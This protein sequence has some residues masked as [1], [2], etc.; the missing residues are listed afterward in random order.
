MAQ[1]QKL[2]FGDDITALIR[3]AKRDKFAKEEDQRIV[4]VVEI[5]LQLT[6]QTLFQDIA[7]QKHLNELLD[8]DLEQRISLL[9]AATTSDSNEDK[10]E[11]NKEAEKNEEKKDEKEEVH[12]QKTN[13]QNVNEKV[14]NK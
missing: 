7:L 9:T 1:R 8:A 3:A 13:T 4:Q 11:E 5:L 2:P 12:K 14:N 6:K 10:Q